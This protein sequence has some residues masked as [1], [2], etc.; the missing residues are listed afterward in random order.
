MHVQHNVPFCS[1]ALLQDI[2]NV[3]S[4]DDSQLGDNMFYTVN[5]S[6]S[7]LESN[8][9]S[10][11]I[12]TSSCTDGLCSYAF[13]VSSS[14]CLPSAGINITAYGT[15][16]LGDGPPSSEITISECTSMSI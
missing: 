4:E 1:L 3:T 7:S 11:T 6:N 2:S 16:A 5:F 15:N 10:A 8:C 14:S 12:Q 9:G 13:E